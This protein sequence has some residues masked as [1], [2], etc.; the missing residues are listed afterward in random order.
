M[1]QRIILVCSLAIMGTVIA[2]SCKKQK[3]FVAS[4]ETFSNYTSW[5]LIA[6]KS[7][8]SPSL[9]SAHNGND[10]LAARRVY[11][12]GN[13]SRTKGQYPVGTVLLK[14]T[15]NAA[16]TIIELTAMVKRGKAFNAAQND[17][18]WFMLN[19]TDGKIMDRGAS[20]MNGMCGGCHSA[21]SDKD[22]VFSK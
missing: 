14:E 21:L 3:E 12:K 17:W 1:K 9:S 7:G 6:Q 10:S 18:E 11:D 16:G 8:P 15:K 5:K 13:E 22:Y 20:L 19:P 2:T 4:D